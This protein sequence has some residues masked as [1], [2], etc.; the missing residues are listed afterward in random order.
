[1][2]YLLIDP[3]YIGEEKLKEYYGNPVATYKTWNGTFKIEGQNVSV[4]SENIHIYEVS[5]NNDPYLQ[6]E[7]AENPYAEVAY[8][9]RI[10]DE[11]EIFE[12]AQK[13]Y[14]ENNKK[15]KNGRLQ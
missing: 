2:K 3:C 14:K 8:L 13:S 9:E 1:M 15:E 7:I 4:N 11:E 12:A 5:D 10:P 6:Q